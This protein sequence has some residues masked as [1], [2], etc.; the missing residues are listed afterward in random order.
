MVQ[1]PQALIA[2]FREAMKGLSLTCG[3]IQHE[4]QPA[5]HKPHRLSA[6]KCAVYVFS[7]SPRWAQRCPAAARR[8]LKVGKVGP[9]SNARFQSQH[10]E[11]KRAGSTLA[12]AL[13]TSRVLWQYLG[14]TELKSEQAGEWI[15]DNTDRDNFYLDSKDNDILGHFEKYIRGKLGPVFE[16]G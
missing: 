2:E 10:Y 13:V 3:E 15:R 11:P 16:G 8:V 14:I 5:P 7:L 12:G 1:N 6:G 4:L 9:N